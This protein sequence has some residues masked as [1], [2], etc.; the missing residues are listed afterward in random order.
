MELFCRFLDINYID[1]E[2]LSVKNHIKNILSEVNLSDIP[3]NKKH[4]YY[5]MYTY[6]YHP[7]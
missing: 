7:K 6:F 1:K 2:I 5:I 3:K 4:I